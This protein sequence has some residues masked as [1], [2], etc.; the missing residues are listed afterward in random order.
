MKKQTVPTIVLSVV[1]CLTLVCL[2]AAL[3]GLMD[4]RQSRDGL[5]QQVAQLEEEKQQLN[6]QLAQMTAQLA[7][8]ESSAKAGGLASWTIEITP[9]A[10]NTGADIALNAVPEAW[11]ESLAA[12]LMVEL[13][14]QNI[15]TAPCQWD[16]SAFTVTVPVSA[17]DGYSYQLLLTLP[18][19]T[20]LPYEL[21]SPDSPVLDIP[22]Y[23]ATSLT[24]YCNLVLEEWEETSEGILLHAAYAQVQLPRIGGM[25]GNG[26]D[27]ARLVLTHNGTEVYTQPVTLEPAEAVDSYA[28]A[29]SGITL[30]LPETEADDLLELRL[31]VVLKSGTQL[32]ASGITWFRN[33]DALDAVVG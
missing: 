32:T 4:A 3:F 29:I 30:P 18:N 23:L 15:L 9:W 26:V 27:N 25:E 31:E 21:T 8:A 16:G 24:T 20:G 13:D 1:L 17:A 22:V 28:L 10:D 33:G 11:H 2:V 5:R 14:G 7:E 12:Q 19:G 6:E